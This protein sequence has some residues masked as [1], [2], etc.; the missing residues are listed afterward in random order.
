MDSI[1]TYY[2]RLSMM[3][4]LL[5]QLYEPDEVERWFITPQPRLQ[6]R[7]PVDLLWSDIG[8][9]EVSAIIHQVLDGAFI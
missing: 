6:D 7:R 5:L 9:L 8:Y 4:Q 2:F 1:D 3:K